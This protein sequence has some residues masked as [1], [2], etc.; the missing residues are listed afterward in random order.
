MYKCER[1]D[2]IMDLLTENEYATVEF[3]AK[4]MNISPS[5][6]RRDLKNL[7]ERGLV[8]RSYGGVKL[9]NATGKRIPFSLRS[10]ENSHLKKQIAK[11]ALSLI[12]E[13]DVVFLDGS[14]TVLFL[15]DLLASVNG[16][17]VITNGIDVMSCLSNYDVRAYCTGG[18]KSKD[19]EAVLV[20]D[21]TQRFLRDI[22]ADVAIFSVQS[23][24]D[25]GDCFDCYAEEVAVRKVMLQNARKKIL[26]CDSS[27]WNRPS[28]FYQCSTADVDYIVC[29]K[30][31]NTFF[32]DPTPEK[33]VLAE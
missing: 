24:N 22:R 3:L 29:D 31:L 19:N 16:I 11:A 6:I 25:A 26:L 14:S 8:N 9:A 33:Y 15:A 7:E 28:T 20:G 1:E 2:E 27:K 32:K 17:T 18:A 4:K 13:G 23:M 10:Q 30:E 5:S 21:Y 12:N